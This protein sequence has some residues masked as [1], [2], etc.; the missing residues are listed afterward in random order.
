MSKFV[1]HPTPMKNT[2]IHYGD[3]LRDSISEMRDDLALLVNSGP[4]TLMMKG[5]PNRF[6]LSELD[7]CLN[8]FGCGFFEKMEL[9][10]DRMTGVNRGYA[11]IRLPDIDRAVFFRRVL[12]GER[13]SRNSRKVVSFDL[14]RNP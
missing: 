3:N 8:S 6:R 11:F 1:R 9:P 13:L 4:V 14:A 10:M 7:K 12:R 5:I 2:F